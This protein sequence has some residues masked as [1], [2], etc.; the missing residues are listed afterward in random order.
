MPGED[1]GFWLIEGIAGYFESLFL[2]DK[3]ATVGGWDASRLQFARYR[4]LVG[5][6]MM[7]MAELT[8]DGRLA[9]QQRQD[10]ARWYA[11]AIAQTH[12]LLDGGNPQ[13]CLWVYQQLAER[14]KIRTDL[15]AGGA[16]VDLPA[17]DRSIRGFL[18]IDD[19]HI[20]SN[21]AGWPLERLCLAGCQVTEKGLSRITP[22]PNLRWLDLA[23]LPISNEAVRR[24]APKPSSLEQLTLEA[25]RVDADLVDWLR[26]AKGLRELDLSWTP[27]G[28]SVIDAVSTAGE[29]STLWMTGTQVSD[30]S[31]DPIAQMRHLHSVDLQRTKVTDAGIARLRAARPKLEINPLELRSP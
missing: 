19:A 23:R 30:R 21:P 27:M 10:I 28:D 14:Y 6:D 4:M 20:S 12:H 2:G 25:T 18:S 29:L 9:V 1:F 22:S 7:S 24:L 15:P 13:R 3:V 16:A 26:E 17:V 5:G 31:I 8:G 11:H